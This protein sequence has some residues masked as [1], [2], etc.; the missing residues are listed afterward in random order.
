MQ[1]WGGGAPSIGP[2]ALETLATPLRGYAKV[3]QVGEITKEYSFGG[4]TCRI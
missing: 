3:F 2:R 4:P 1:D